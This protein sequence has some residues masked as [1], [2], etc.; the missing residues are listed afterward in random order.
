MYMTLMLYS[1]D[2]GDDLVGAALYSSGVKTQ[3]GRK[4]VSP[5]R[6]N[7]SEPEIV[8]TGLKVKSVAE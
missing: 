5:E 6:P 7:T 3:T 1:S 4:D 8:E 2:G